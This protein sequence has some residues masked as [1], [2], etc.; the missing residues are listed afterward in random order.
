MGS[1]LI[2]IQW[3]VFVWAPLNGETLGLA[4]GY[5]LLPLVLVLIGRFLLN[6]SL[7]N[8]QWAAA[9]LGFSAVLAKLVME[10]D[11]SWVALIIA[12]GYPLYF[13]L[14]RK[15]SIGVLSAFFIENLL[16]FPLAWWACVYYGDV[17]SPFDYSNESLLMFL[18]LGVLGSMG[19]L[20]LLS[21]SRKLPIALFGLLGYLEP[22]FLFLISIFILGEMV[23]SNERLSYFLIATAL[24]L[25]TIDG[26]R[27]LYRSQYKVN[28][29]DT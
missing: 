24:F 9:M 1:L 14:R 27:K 22:L 16:L 4:M 28:Q 26:V 2:G 21:A 11:F 13:L 17:N 19:M 23:D 12:L 8:L 18:G 5:S 15:Q 25:L 20:G 3:G 10:G 6:E 7:S 29:L